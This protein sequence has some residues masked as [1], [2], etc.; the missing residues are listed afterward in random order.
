VSQ[1][2]TADRHLCD[3]ERS[4]MSSSAR[5]KLHSTRGATLM[6]AL[7]F[8]IVCAVVGAIVLAA[9][10]ATAGRAAGESGSNSSTSSLTS[11]TESKQEYYTLT[12]A[13]D[14][15]L[16]EMKGKYIFINTVKT[17]TSVDSTAGSPVYVMKYIIQDSGSSKPD[18]SE[19]TTAPEITDFTT[20]PQLVQIAAFEYAADAKKSQPGFLPDDLQTIT[21][22]A[23]FRISA[24][25]EKL[26]EVSCSFDYPNKTGSSDSSV[27]RAAMQ[28]TDNPKL[29]LSVTI[30]YSITDF[31]DMTD[32][33]TVRTITKKVTA[34]NVTTTTETSS[35]EKMVTWKTATISTN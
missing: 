21:P 10:T 30:P 23:G 15:L 19:W 27:I 2:F 33:T 35:V 7:L 14:A 17:I 16:S 9:A 29:S 34:D 6:L 25:S 32:S 8:F 26:P 11:R 4:A 5:E 22:P 3:P 20:I 28:L 24:L 18:D 12:S 1:I 31:T 13:A